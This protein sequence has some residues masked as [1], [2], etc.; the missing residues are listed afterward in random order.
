M[1]AVRLD[2]PL[3]P[4]AWALLPL[5]AFLGGTFLYAGLS[6]LFDTHYLDD[7][8]PLGVHAQ[9]LH[10]AARSPIGRLVSLSAEHSTLTGLAIAFVEITIGLG[11]LLGLFTRL[12]ALGGVLL[13]VSYF[14]TVSWTTWPYYYGAD[15]GFAFAWTPL[16]IAGDAGVLS[17][18]AWLRAKARHTLGLPMHASPDE[19]AAVQ[20]DVERRTVLRGGLIAAS[21]TAVGVPVGSALARSH[22]SVDSSTDSA[23]PQAKAGPVI[24]VAADLAVGSSMSFTASNGAPAYLLHPAP[25]T[26]LAFNATCTHHGCPVTYVGPGFRCPCH[27]S[28]FDENGQVTGGP[29]PTPLTQIPITVINGQVTMV[30]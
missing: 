18:T 3:R 7:A 24:A 23:S 27:G 29:A 9:M 28:S 17:S 16:L 30:N 4:P 14:L 20:N 22:R 2:S 6:K 15:I 26:F 11:T 13:S 1:T 12:A 10:A 5:R 21:A 19:G 25:D 8:S